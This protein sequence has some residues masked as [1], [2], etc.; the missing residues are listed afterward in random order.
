MLSVPWDST[1]GWGIPKLEPYK[2]LSLDPA[3]AV[4]HY[5]FCCFEGMKAYKDA[6]GNVRLFRPEKNIHRLNTSAERIA[7]PTFDE[8]EVL[9]LL[10]KFTELE[11]RWI[12]E[13]DDSLPRSSP[14]IIS[15]LKEKI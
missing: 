9:K 2:A 3:A 12:P 5:A 8:G 10:A 11:S 7:L 1:H 15:W 4:F 14:C 13:Y 6:K